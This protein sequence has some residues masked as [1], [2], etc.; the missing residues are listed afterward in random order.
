MLRMRRGRTLLIAAALVVTGTPAATTDA[1]DVR[2]RANVTLAD[3]R[4]FRGYPL[5]YPGGAAAG[6]R[7]SAIVRINRTT[8]ARYTEFTFLYGTC[9]PPP[10]GGC[11]T[12]VHVILWP[13]CYRYETRYRIPRAERRRVRGVPARLTTRAGFPRLELYAARTTIVVNGWGLTRTRD[14][15]A[16]AASLRGLNTRLLTS[17]PLPPRP[18]HAGRT[19][20]CR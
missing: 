19:I 3:A 17:R 6:H 11:T 20:R 16:V 15:L 10:S 14:V 18:P 1:A 2:P 8:P 7:L 5:Y 12:P 4:A 9:E 13:A